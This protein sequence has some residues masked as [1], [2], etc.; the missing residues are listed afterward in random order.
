MGD[1]D[2][3]EDLEIR[4]PPDGGAGALLI[5]GLDLKGLLLGA[6]NLALLEVQRVLVAVAPDGDIHVLRGVLGGARA[7]AIGAEREVVVA[8]LV[9]VV[10][11]AGVELAEDEL[12]VEALLGGVPVQRAAAAVVLD[13][14]GLVGEGGEGDQLAKALARFV[15]RVG[16]D[17]EGGV[18]AAVE[19]VRAKDDG[20]TQ[21]DAFLVL[22]LTDAVVAIVCGALCHARSLG[23]PLPAPGPHRAC[24]LVATPAPRRDAPAAASS[25]VWG[26]VIWF[27]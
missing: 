22:E 13:L 7:Q 12:P 2:G 4:A 27:R 9:V 24:V 14:D 19:A 25:C 3:G 17:L 16:E 26:R 1:V 21:A 20:G 6:Y 5:G 8:A 11:A 10:L 18:R 23:A 15:N